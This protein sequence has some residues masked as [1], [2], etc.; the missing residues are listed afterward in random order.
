MGNDG[1]MAI[2]D[3]GYLTTAASRVR[4]A[5]TGLLERGALEW[6]GDFDQRPHAVLH[7]RATYSLRSCQASV[8][9]STPRPPEGPALAGRVV[10]P[11]SGLDRRLRRTRT[12]SSPG[13]SQTPGG[14]SR[15]GGHAISFAR[16]RHHHKVA[17]FEQ[18]GWTEV[19][20]E[21]RELADWPNVIGGL[22]AKSPGTRRRARRICRTMAS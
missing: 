2:S 17:D 21:L 6:Q 16:L 8:R 10:E 9:P 12:K 1:Y 15:R 14:G 3:D 5:G 13:K 19:V 18:D 7:G 11:L 20:L 22:E 4:E